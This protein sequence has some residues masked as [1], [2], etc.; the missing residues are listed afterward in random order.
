MALSGFTALLR[1]LNDAWDAQAVAQSRARE[2]AVEVRNLWRDCRDN[3]FSKA[4]ESM[5]GGMSD[6]SRDL[7]AKARELQLR[8]KAEGR[9]RLAELNAEANAA[10]AAGLITGEQGARLDAALARAAEGLRE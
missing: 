10:I 1:D 2:R 3:S 7:A 6:M 4:I 9:R 8:R 5:M